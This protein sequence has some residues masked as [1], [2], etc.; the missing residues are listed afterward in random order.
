MR[1]KR[2]QEKKIPRREFLKKGAQ[3]GAI[4]VASPM[5]LRGVL[6]EATRIAPQARVRQFVIWAGEIWNNCWRWP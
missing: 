6:G 2:L 5:I 1:K 4:L 3:G